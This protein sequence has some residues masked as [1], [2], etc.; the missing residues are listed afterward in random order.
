[1]PPME[2]MG[3]HPGRMKVA[4]DG[5]RR[6]RLVTKEDWTTNADAAIWTPSD[7][8]TLQNSRPTLQNFRKKCC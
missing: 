1:M 4:A 7:G 2:G 8:P 3:R 5:Q 6:L